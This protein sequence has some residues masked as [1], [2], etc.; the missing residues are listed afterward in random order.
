MKSPKFAAMSLDNRIERRV[1]GDF[2]VRKDGVELLGVE[3]VVDDFV[4]R[5]VEFFD[6]RGGNGMAK[7]SLFLVA[8]QDIDVH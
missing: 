8:D 1:A 5:G 3:I 7:A 2:I 4:S 6:R